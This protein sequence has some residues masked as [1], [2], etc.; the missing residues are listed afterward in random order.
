MDGHALEAPHDAPTA[1]APSPRGLGEIELTLSSGVAESD[2]V[3]M[4]VPGN[5]ICADCTA[6]KPPVW[7]S[8]NLGV[9]LCLECAGVHRRLGVHV[10]KVLSLRLDDWTVEQVSAMVNKGNTLVNANLE[11]SLAAGVKPS[12]AST[13]SDREAFIRAKYELSSFAAGGDGQLPAVAAGS[14]SKA[15]SVEYCGLIFIR[16]ACARNLVNM[17]LLSPSDPYMILKLGTQS[18][19]TRT[20]RDDND[21]V[22]REMLSLNVADTTQMLRV[23]IWD[24]D[25]VSPDELIGTA[26]VSIAEACARPSQPT[27]VAVELELTPKAFRMTRPSFLSCLPCTGAYKRSEPSIVEFELKFNSLS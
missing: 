25:D 10:S 3:I 1:A 9:V 21:P 4:R 16:K 26:V 19:R 22:W 17:D 24:A 2:A 6:G 23:E 5:V 14:T 8:S 13:A 7:A 11:A 27:L 12:A 18:M 20:V 15:G